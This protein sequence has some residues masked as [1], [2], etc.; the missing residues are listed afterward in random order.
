MMRRERAVGGV[1]QRSFESLLGLQ[2]RPKRLREAADLWASI[3]TQSGME[4]RDA[5]WSHPDLLPQLPSETAAP[6]AASSHIYN[7]SDTS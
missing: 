6:H 5:R 1:A 7:D 4:E 3:D 2:L